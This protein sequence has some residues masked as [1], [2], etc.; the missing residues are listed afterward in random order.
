MALKSHSSDDPDGIRGFFIYRQGSPNL[1]PLAMICNFPEKC[2]RILKS[3]LYSSPLIRENLI[4]GC[5]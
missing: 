5:L 4:K 2:L 3:D 1:Y